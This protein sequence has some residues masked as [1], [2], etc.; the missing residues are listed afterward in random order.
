MKIGNDPA[1]HTLH[2]HL[3]PLTHHTTYDAEAIGMI[4]VSQGRL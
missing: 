1:T 4:L 3:G 2:Y